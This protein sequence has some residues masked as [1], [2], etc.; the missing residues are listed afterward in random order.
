MVDGS[1]AGYTGREGRV[2]KHRTIT[3]KWLVTEQQDV[4][5]Q[6]VESLKGT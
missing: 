3:R 4:H 6:L 5:N 1:I 2:G